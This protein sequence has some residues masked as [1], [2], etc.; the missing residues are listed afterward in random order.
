MGRALW[1]CV[2]RRAIIRQE[3]GSGFG[4]SDAAV[5]AMPSGAGCRAAGVVVG[6]RYIHTVTESVHKRDLRAC[7]DLLAAWLGA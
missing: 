3:R 7:V 1:R 6:T 5:S 2:V 4:I